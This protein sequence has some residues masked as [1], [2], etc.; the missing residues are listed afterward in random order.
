MLN[1]VG[2]P[3]PC[4]EVRFWAP[5]LQGFSLIM[6]DVVMP[7][8]SLL[9]FGLLAVPSHLHR[10]M[11]PCWL[12]VG[13][14]SG[15]EVYLKHQYYQRALRRYL[16][17][18]SPRLSRWDCTQTNPWSNCCAP[19]MG[20]YSWNFDHGNWPRQT[21]TDCTVLRIVWLQFHCWT[22][23]FQNCLGTS[24]DPCNPSVLPPAASPRIAPLARFQRSMGRSPLCR[25]KRQCKG[26]TSRSS[27]SGGT[28]WSQRGS[29][30][31]WG[32]A[33]D[34]VPL[35]VWSTYVPSNLH[36]NVWSNV[37]TAC[38]PS[39]IWNETD[40]Q[41]GM[42]VMMYYIVYVFQMAGL[43]GNENLVSSSYV[44]RCNFV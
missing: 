36:W 10:K 33:F 42:N 41:C 25:R 15:H 30:N 26:P 3:P 29:S 34:I 14:F 31:C 44:L 22:S 17:I 8:K 12:S 11:L 19:T 35:V 37:A 24:N 27:C 9:W 28:R 18:S 5:W 16:F 20:H 32:I 7:F 13:K 6:W 38:T 39:R 40:E 2:S 1:R 4:P 23:V 43:T 21:M